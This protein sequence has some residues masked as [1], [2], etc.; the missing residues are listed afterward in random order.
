MTDNPR[1]EAPV[2][3]GLGNTLLL[4]ISWLWVGVPL[5]W[6]VVKTVQ[7]SIALFR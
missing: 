2:T 3:P 5:V 1:H 7:T 6:G 4:A